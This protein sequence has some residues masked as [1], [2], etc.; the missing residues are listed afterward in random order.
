MNNK[1]TISVIL[2]VYNGEKYVYQAIRSVLDQSY[3]DLELF[4]IDDGS[5]DGTAQVIQ[6]ISDPRLRL[7]QNRH[8]LGLCASRNIGLDAAR[9]DWVAFIDADD[10]WDRA[11]LEK[12]MGI[13]TK[14]PSAFLGSGIMMCLSDKEDQLIP[15]RQVNAR[16]E[17]TPPLIFFPNAALFVERGFDVN[18]LCRLA[19]INEKKIRF[20]EKFKGLDWLDFILKLF[21]NG[22]SLVVLNEPLYFYRRNPKSLSSS[23]QGVLDE[24]RAAKL[25][26]HE[27]WIDM[28]IRS[29]ILTRSRKIQKRLVTAALREKRYREAIRHGLARPSGLLF[30]FYR[31]PTYFFECYVMPFTLKKRKK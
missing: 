3:P 5:T 2:P 9:G 6:R 18:P 7:I 10:A 17:E 15:W 23:Y 14:H 8:N 12:L 13:G 31:V 11:Y 1:A 29:R 27:G 4:I 16:S 30:L 24:L 22:L 26:S 19:F 28:R 25:L 20:D 21:H